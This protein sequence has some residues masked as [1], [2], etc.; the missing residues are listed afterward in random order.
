MPLSYRPTQARGNSSRLARTMPGVAGTPDRGPDPRSE[1]GGVSHGSPVPQ[2]AGDVRGMV[3]DNHIGAG[4]LEARERLEHD[5]PLVD[6][7]V[8]G[9]GLDHRVLARDVVRRH[10]DSEPLL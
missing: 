9:G 7:A 2:P 4:A 6:P 10:R 1:D 5:P 8:G 3:G